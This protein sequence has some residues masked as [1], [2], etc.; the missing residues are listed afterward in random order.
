MAV[1]LFVIFL[2]SK[3]NFITACLKILSP[4]FLLWGLALNLY[5]QQVYLKY[6]NLLQVI[7]AL[8]FF[9]IALLLSIFLLRDKTISGQIRLISIRTSI[10]AGSFVIILTLIRKMPDLRRADPN[11]KNVVMLVLDG[12]STQYLP[13]YNP[14]ITLQDFSDIASGGMLYK[15]CHTNFTYTGD[16]FYTLYSGERQKSGFPKNNLMLKRVRG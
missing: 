13:L 16:Y 11:R 9:C 15:N 4:A 10:L 3:Y 14:E 1:M 12:L 6:S 2:P 7:L 5:P 8:G